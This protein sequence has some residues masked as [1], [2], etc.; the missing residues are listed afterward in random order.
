MLTNPRFLG[1]ELP[2]YDANA[3]VLNREAYLK[4]P[5]TEKTTFVR[6]IGIR[7]PGI[8][9]LKQCLTLADRELQKAAE[10][11]EGEVVDYEWGL[12]DNSVQ[13]LEP[14]QMYQDGYELLPE[15]HLLVAEVPVIDRRRT[16][17]GWYDDLCDNANKYVANA[18]GRR[19]GDIGPNQFIYGVLRGTQTIPATWLVDIEPR[20]NELK[21]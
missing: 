12:F 15:G 17:S 9:T 3:E 2:V 16:F 10:I 18:D 11:C 21:N 4:V 8:N 6:V 7:A 1:L 20:F 14:H 13:G 19:L 5:E